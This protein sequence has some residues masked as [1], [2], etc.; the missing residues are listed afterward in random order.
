M[1]SARSFSSSSLHNPWYP[2]CRTNAWQFR[3]ATPPD[4]AG[5]AVNPAFKLSSP[6]GEAGIFLHVT[7]IF[8]HL[9]LLLFICMHPPAILLRG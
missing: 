4:P 8:Y 1:T 6:P 2:R 9:P 7:Y 5:A 3:L